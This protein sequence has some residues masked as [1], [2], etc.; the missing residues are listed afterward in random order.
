[1]NRKKKKQKGIGELCTSHAIN[2][3][4]NKWPTGNKNGVALYKGWH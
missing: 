4:I 2:D 1:M 3:G